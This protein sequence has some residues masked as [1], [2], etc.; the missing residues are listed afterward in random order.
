MHVMKT[1]ARALFSSSWVALGTSWSGLGLVLNA[2]GPLLG[3]LGS[4]LGDLDWIN[5]RVSRLALGNS[6]L[7]LSKILGV[8][9]G[10]PGGSEWPRWGASGSRAEILGAGGPKTEPKVTPNRTQTGSKSMMENRC[11]ISASSRSSGRRL[12]AI[13]GRFG[14]DLGVMIVDISLDFIRVFGH[15]QF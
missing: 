1:C 9:G 13:L 12:G 11:E 4:Y 8:P 14:A 3:D 7:D 2:L 6:R 10:H 15:N 5:L